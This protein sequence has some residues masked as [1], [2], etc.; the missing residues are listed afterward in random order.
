[1]GSHQSLVAALVPDL[2]SIKKQIIRD[3]FHDLAVMGSP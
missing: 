3:E 1:M 2:I